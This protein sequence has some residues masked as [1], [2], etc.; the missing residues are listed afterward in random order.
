MMETFCLTQCYLS[1]S[2]PTGSL[3]VKLSVLVCD[4]IT[5]QRRKIPVDSNKHKQALDMVIIDACM[6]VL[7]CF[8]FYLN[9]T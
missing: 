5:D 7:T 6:W 2:G 4:I 8:L 3:A 9:R 1:F